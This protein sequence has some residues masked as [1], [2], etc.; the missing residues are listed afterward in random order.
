[1][2]AFEDVIWFFSTVFISLL[3]VILIMRIRVGNPAI[4]ATW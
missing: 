3:F 1:M 2:T 4:L